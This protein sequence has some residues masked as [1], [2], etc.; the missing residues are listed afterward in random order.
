MPKKPAKTP[1]STAAT[2]VRYRPRRS[3]TYSVQVRVGTLAAYR[4]GAL[5]VDQC[6]A[7]PGV[8]PAVSAA[9]LEADFGTA[10]AA[11][12][13]KTILDKGEYVMT[14]AERAAEV[15]RLKARAAQHLS[16]CFVEAGP[17]GASIPASRFAAVLSELRFVPQLGNQSVERQLDPFIRRVRDALRCVPRA[18]GPQ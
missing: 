6:V 14:T 4:A 18:D 15:A 10:D 13:V 11:E 12:V 9:Q 16:D 8:D 1:S 17:A 2:R 5:S 3:N 7:S